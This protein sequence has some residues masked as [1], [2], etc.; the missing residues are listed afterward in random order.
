MKRGLSVQIKRDAP[1]I[2]IYK[3]GAVKN[4]GA[5]IESNERSW[6]KLPWL[7]KQTNQQLRNERR[8]CVTRAPRRR[9]GRLISIDFLL[10]SN[11]LPPTKEREIRRWRSKSRGNNCCHPIENLER[12]RLLCFPHRF[13]I[14]ADEKKKRGPERWSSFTRQ[15]VRSWENGQLDLHIHVPAGPLPGIFRRRSNKNKNGRKILFFC[16]C[17]WRWKRGANWEKEQ[18]TFCVTF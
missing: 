7:I 16:G 2:G 15:P 4:N 18:L 3:G 14:F 8:L 13:Q 1:R 10:R 9:S 11:L 17:P 5:K 6:E 12:P